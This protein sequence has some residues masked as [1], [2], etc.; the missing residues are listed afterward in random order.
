MSSAPKSIAMSCSRLM[1][2]PR[3]GGFGDCVACVCGVF[4][5]F[6]DSTVFPDDDDDETDDR[7]DASPAPFRDA[8][9]SCRTSPP[10]SLVSAKSLEPRVAWSWVCPRRDFSTRA[11]RAIPDETLLQHALP[12]SPLP[13]PEA[14]RDAPP[15]RRVFVLGRV[16]SRATPPHA[17]DARCADAA[18]ATPNAHDMTHVRR[19]GRCR[20]E[21][22]EMKCTPPSR[23]TTRPSTYPRTHREATLALSVSAGRLPLSLRSR[24][25]ARSGTMPRR[26]LSKRGRGVVEPTWSNMCLVDKSDCQ[27]AGQRS[28]RRPHPNHTFSRSTIMVHRVFSMIAR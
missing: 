24:L 10:V 23:P 2:V 1:P 20:R 4:W 16:R 21:T 18:A 22:S 14:Q 17:G 13:S 28:A 26:Y 6:F 12:R 5:P 19:F 8:F 9:R 27:L 15:V 7:F 25:C 3:V 11:H